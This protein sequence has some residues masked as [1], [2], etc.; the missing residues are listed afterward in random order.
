VGILGSRVH[1]LRPPTT[2]ASSPRWAVR[3]GIRWR[4]AP[5]RWP[6][7][8]PWSS[9]RRGLLSGDSARRCAK[10]RSEWTSRSPSP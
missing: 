2:P 3:A 9:A 5:C 8:R 1:P 4:R 7:S 6:R 10:R